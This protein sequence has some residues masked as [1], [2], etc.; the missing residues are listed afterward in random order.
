MIELRS[1]SKLWG[2]VVALAPTNLLIAEGSFTVL[3]GP[4]GCGKTTTLRLIA[5]LDSASSGQIFV[6]GARR[7]RTAALAAPSGD[8]VP[9]LRVI[10]AF[11]RR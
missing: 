5:G 7:Y 9:E 6:G 8:G 4:S 11:K 3:L 2:D 1:V 10:P